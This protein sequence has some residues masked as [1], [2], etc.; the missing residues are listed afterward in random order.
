M[1]QLAQTTLEY[2]EDFSST[3][4]ASHEN[5]LSLVETRGNFSTYSQLGFIACVYSF[6]IGPILYFSNNTTAGK[7]LMMVKKHRSSS[8]KWRKQTQIHIKSYDVPVGWRALNGTFNLVQK[9]IINLKTCRR[10]DPFHSDLFHY[11]VLQFQHSIH[12]VGRK[13]QLKPDH[14][15]LH[16]SHTTRPC[17]QHEHLELGCTSWFPDVQ[18]MLLSYLL[19]CKRDIDCNHTRSL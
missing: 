1:H 15:T 7:A 9:V 16:H 12:P 13:F 18:P 3:S 11:Q 6:S 14:T 2:L 19:S 4:L 17:C 10:Y 5:L 8:I